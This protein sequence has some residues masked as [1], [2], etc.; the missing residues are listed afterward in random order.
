MTKP[1]FISVLVKPGTFSVSR[2]VSIQLI[3]KRGKKDL[4]KILAGKN[5]RW[6]RSRLAIKGYK[7]IGELTFRMF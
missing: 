2:Q 7:R 1:M 4:V 5:F 6:V 3:I